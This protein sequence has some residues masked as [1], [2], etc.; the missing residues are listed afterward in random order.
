MLSAERIKE[1][2]AT[3]RPI[4]ANIVVLAAQPL[5]HIHQHRQQNRR[6][7]VRT[8]YQ[9]NPYTACR[10]STAQL[11][12]QK[13][14]RIDQIECDDQPSGNEQ[15]P[16]SDLGRLDLRAVVDRDRDAEPGTQ[17]P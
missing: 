11:K 12:T 15:T 9:Q 17:T 2:M 13:L 10:H 7:S 16:Q 6:N 5:R 8:T 1:S 14:N 4:R 3:D